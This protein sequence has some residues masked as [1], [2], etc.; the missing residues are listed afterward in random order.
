MPFASRRRPMLGARLDPRLAACAVLAVAAIAFVSAYCGGGAA[1]T[2]GDATA[3]VHAQTTARS[4]GS[5]P[6]DTA[7][8]ALPAVLPPVFCA[9]V[10]RMERGDVT[11]I[12]DGDTFDVLID[13]REE[14][15]RF[16]GIDTPER[17]DDC[18]AEA[19]EA[20]RALIE[21][22]VRLLPDTRN[23]DRNGRLLRYVYT[24]LG[25]SVDAALVANGFARAWRD[26]GQHRDALVVL[27]AEARSA[28]RGCLWR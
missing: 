2:D 25:L 17:G 3:T 13:G 11:R 6:E 14:R 9:D 16:F 7:D 12:I 24:P 5:P 4:S 8:C 28:R 1:T 15:I 10:T 27:E 18:F 23:R 19:T 22:G 20:T 26:D 21:E